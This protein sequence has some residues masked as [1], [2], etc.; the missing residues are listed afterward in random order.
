MLFSRKKKFQFVLVPFV[1]SEQVYFSI[2]F[3]ALQSQPRRVSGLKW[4]PDIM[5]RYGCW[6]QP[7][8]VSGMKSCAPGAAGV[9]QALNSDRLDFLLLL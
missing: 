7:R 8:G 3:L 5:A 2:S 6:S 1:Q 9:P 4:V